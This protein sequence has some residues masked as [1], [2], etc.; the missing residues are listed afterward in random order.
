VVFNCYTDDEITIVEGE[1]TLE[2]TESAET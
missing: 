1:P 2:E